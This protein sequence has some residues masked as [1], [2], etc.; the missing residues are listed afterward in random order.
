[1]HAVAR[2]R[3]A[4]DLG[5]GLLEAILLQVDPPNKIVGPRKFRTDL[6]GFL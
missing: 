3:L 2:L 1:L 4:L 5:Q 6:Q